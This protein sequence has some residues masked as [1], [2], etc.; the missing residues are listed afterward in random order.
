MLYYVP[1][2]FSN[3]KLDDSL[4]QRLRVRFQQ[5]TWVQYCMHSIVRGLDNN[6]V[7]WGWYKLNNKTN[8]EY[9]IAPNNKHKSL[10][11]FEVL[12]VE[13]ATNPGELSK[14]NIALYCWLNFKLLDATS[15]QDLTFEYMNAVITLLQFEGAEG[16]QRAMRK[17]DIFDFEGLTANN[18]YKPVMGH[19][20]GF[21]LTFD[22]Y[23][24]IN[25][26]YNIQD[27]STAIPISDSGT[28]T[29]A[30]LV[31]GVLTINHALNSTIIVS[32]TINKANGEII[33]VMP[34]EIVNINQV[35]IDLGGI[36]V[37]THTWT[38]TAKPMLI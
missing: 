9:Q 34:N 22:I 26:C 4:I 20:G 7:E 36:E 3:P 25:T 21:K 8:R 15:Y 23:H 14:Y 17:D 13:Y 27:M 5:Q 30:D 11:F 1:S 29:A 38:L 35:K 19:F 10:I 28:F 16:V 37:G 2:Y 32:L 12:N 6:G 33:T 31:A 18:E 24:D